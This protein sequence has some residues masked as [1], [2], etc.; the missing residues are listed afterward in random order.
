VSELPALNADALREDLPP[1][2]RTL[3]V[4]AETGSTNADLL[5]RAAAGEDI[6]GVVL[7]AEH[8]TS[9]RGRHGRSWV[10]TPRAQLTLSVGVAAGE[11][12]ADSWGWLTL[13]TGVA[14][15][16]TVVA[17][18][19]VDAGLKWPNDVLAGDK[20]LAGILSEVAADARSKK[21]SAPRK[22]IVVGVGLNV[23]SPGEQL[24]EGATSLVDLGVAAPDRHR[25]A[26]RLLRELGDRVVGWRA[27]GGADERLMTDYRDR[28]VTIGSQV[29]VVLPGDRELAGLAASID[30]RGR[31]CLE[32]DGETV[33]VSAGDVVHLRPIRRGGI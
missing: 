5:A 15:V 25:L 27:A 24:T 6:D 28:S 2:W 16:D 17:E 20:K 9:G 26:R 8:Q 30:D 10:G 33:A 22:L 12:D 14:V 32:S 29:R 21:A 31:L 11:V 4:V 1:P 13:A 7:I 23:A 18:A 19:C 3:D